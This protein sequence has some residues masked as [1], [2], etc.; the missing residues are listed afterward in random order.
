MPHSMS[1]SVD[2]LVKVSEVDVAH[3]SF[4]QVTFTAVNLSTIDSDKSVCLFIFSCNSLP[5]ESGDFFR[6]AFKKMNDLPVVLVVSSSHTKP[7]SIIR[8]LTAENPPDGD[9]VQQTW[10]IGIVTNQV[11]ECLFIH[12]TYW[13]RYKVLHGRGEF[14]GAERQ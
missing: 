12:W 4:R 13:H 1:P 11:K 7:K 8:L 9:L 2:V 14:R 5:W 10:K 3:T 6:L